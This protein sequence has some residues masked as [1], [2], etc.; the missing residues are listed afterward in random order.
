MNTGFTKIYNKLQSTNEKN[1]WE[2]EVTV[3]HNFKVDAMITDSNEG[4]V[5]MLKAFN[6]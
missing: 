1:I 6:S 3:I 5:L 4:K 2:S